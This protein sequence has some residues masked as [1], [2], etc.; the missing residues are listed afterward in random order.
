MAV[1]KL[2]EIDDESNTVTLTSDESGRL[3]RAVSS[4]LTI[5]LEPGT[6][7][8]AGVAVEGDG[9]SR[10]GVPFDLLPAEVAAALTSDMAET[11]DRSMRDCSRLS[12][13]EEVILRLFVDDPAQVASRRAQVCGFGI[14]FE[15]DWPRFRAE[16]TIAALVPADLLRFTSFRDL[17]VDSQAQFVAWIDERLES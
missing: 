3:I 14:Y 17:A 5:E 1:T 13:D 2:V 12:D 10:I 4:S 6:A 8:F 11:F 9:T 15:G 7:V 16:T